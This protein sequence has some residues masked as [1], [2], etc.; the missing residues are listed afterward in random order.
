MNTEGKWVIQP[1]YTLI[2]SQ[3]DSYFLTLNEHGRGLISKEGK[4]IIPPKYE[5]VSMINDSLFSIRQKHFYGIYHLRNGEIIP[6]IHFQLIYQHPFFISSGTNDS[7]NAIYNRNGEKITKIAYDYSHISN[8]HILLYSRK[9]E[10]FFTT[11]IDLEGIILQPEMEGYYLPFNEFGL[12]PIGDFGGYSRV[13]GKAGIIN[14][15]IE[16]HAIPSIYTTE[17]QKQEPNN[18]MVEYFKI[19]TPFNNMN[20]I[21]QIYK[22]AIYILNINNL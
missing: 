5:W 10:Q 18:L 6:P 15:Y 22:T 21:L 17:E 19:N 3:G 8:D 20:E 2:E 7:K 9:G 11:R 14:N 1:D 4:E 16:E 13:N 12:A